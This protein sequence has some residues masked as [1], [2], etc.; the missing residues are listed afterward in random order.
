MGIILWIIFGAIVGFI[1][2]YIDSSVHLSWVERIVVGVVGA[3]V[4]GTV[5]SIL[6]TGRLDFT[7]AGGFDLVSL[8]VAI[9]GALLSLF[10]WKKFVR[11]PSTV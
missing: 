10:V 7:T 3:V 1:A 2:D 9:M 6:T 4:G 5:V 11:R 8:I